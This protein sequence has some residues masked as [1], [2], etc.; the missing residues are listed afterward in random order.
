MWLKKKSEKSEKSMNL[1]QLIFVLIISAGATLNVFAQELVNQ[2]KTIELFVKSG[3]GIV[4]LDQEQYPNVKAVLHV[5][6]ESDLIEAKL[7]TLLKT[8]TTEKKAK[9]LVQPYFQDPE[10]VARLQRAHLA[11]LQ[12]ERY[13]LNQYPVAVI[14][15]GEGLVLGFFDMNEI[16]EFVNQKRQQQGEK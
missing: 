5:V 8:V 15:K 11:K 4:R 3:T 14:N 9:A 16:V 6:D 1:G 2:V 10:F 12:A 13:R 7:N